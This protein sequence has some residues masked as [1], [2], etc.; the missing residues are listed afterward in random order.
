MFGGLALDGSVINP[1]DGDNEAY[2]GQK[3]EARDIL[4]GRVP[5]PA[6]A[7]ALVEDLR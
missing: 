7:Q 3:I 4:N 1:L 5:V 6:G 2:Y